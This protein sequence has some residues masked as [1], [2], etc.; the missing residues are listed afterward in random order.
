[1]AAT[2]LA[3]Q[4]KYFIIKK[5]SYSFKWKKNWKNTNNDLSTEAVYENNVFL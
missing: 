4:E 2:T 3:N 1:M 5:V